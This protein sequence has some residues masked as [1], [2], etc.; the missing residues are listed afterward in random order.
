MSRG[1]VGVDQVDPARDRL[2]PVDDAE[3]LLA[4]R[5]RVAGVEAEARAE[6]ADRVPQPGER[7]EPPGAGVVAA[8]GVLD[9]D[10]QAEATVLRRVGEGLAP[11]V[12][13]DLQVGALVDVTTVDDQP[14]GPDRGRRLG[15][16]QQQLAA[17]DPDAV[18][19]RGDVDPVRRVDVDVELGRAQRVGVGAR[20]GGRRSSAGR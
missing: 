1:V 19:G 2:D 8:G 4:A 6:L 9:E 16:L 14:L 13:A 11:V 15:V 17:R 3:Q 12:E 20:L 10:R 18:V 7:V 5:V